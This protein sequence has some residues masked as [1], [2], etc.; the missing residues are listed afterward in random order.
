MSSVW[1]HQKKAASESLL[2]WGWI[3]FLITTYKNLNLQL[4][5]GGFVNYIVYFVKNEMNAK[6][7]L[8]L[9]HCSFKASYKKTTYL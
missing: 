8:A 9:G 7:M 2:L 4:L 6:C 5:V 3:F 1:L